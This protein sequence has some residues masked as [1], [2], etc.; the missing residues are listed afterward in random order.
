MPAHMLAACIGEVAA[1]TVRVPAE[2]V[3]Q[4]MQAGQHDALGAALRHLWRTDGPRGLYRGLGATLLRDIP[5]AAIQMSL[6]EQCKVSAPAPLSVFLAVAHDHALTG[7][8]ATL[9]P[10]SF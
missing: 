6:Y 1:C 4:R 3:K 8:A 7:G 5:F 9:A 2:L 10:T